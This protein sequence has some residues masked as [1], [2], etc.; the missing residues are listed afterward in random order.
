MEWIK[1]VFCVVVGAPL[2][3]AALLAMTEPVGPPGWQGIDATRIL[4]NIKVLS[5]DEY[6]GRAPA[7]L[8]ETLATGDIEERFKQ[9]GL[10]PGNPDGSYFQKVPMV[11]IKADPS[12]ELVFTDVPSGKREALKFAEDFVAWTKRVQPAIDLE[13]D[14]VFVGY[15]V[16]ALEYRRR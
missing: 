3:F 10:A 14:L 15:G 4:E 12:P 8:A 1:H 5:S 6:E 11:G 13:A 7:S 2:V 16:V 9:A